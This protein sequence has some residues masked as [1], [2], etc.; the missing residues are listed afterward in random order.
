MLTIFC[1]S[2]SPKL[3]E[4]GATRPDPS[5]YKSLMI[6]YSNSDISD[7]CNKIPIISVNNEDDYKEL[8]GVIQYRSSRG[9]LHHV[10]ILKEQM[11][12]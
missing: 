6:E 8:L 5:V 11:S 10:M 9:Y 1:T 3:F 12:Q 4:L 2:V 7:S